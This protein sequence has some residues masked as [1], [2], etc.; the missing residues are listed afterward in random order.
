[1][2]NYFGHFRLT[3]DLKRRRIPGGYIEVADPGT[4]RDDDT[5]VSRAVINPHRVPEPS[6]LAALI[7]GCLALAIGYRIHTDNIS[8]F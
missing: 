4:W 3:G 7:A 5:K 2:D 6:T 8:G 1:M